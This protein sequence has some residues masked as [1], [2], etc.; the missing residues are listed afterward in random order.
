MGAGLGPVQC[1]RPLK[2]LQKEMACTLAAQPDNE[3]DGEDV[4]Y[5]V[6]LIVFDYTIAPFIELSDV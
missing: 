1:K 5:T 6:E 3:D 2:F 4:S